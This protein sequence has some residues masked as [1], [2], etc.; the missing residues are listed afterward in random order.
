[1]H[2]WN[3]NNGGTSHGEQPFDSDL[4]EAQKEVE[5]LK[6]KCCEDKDKGGKNE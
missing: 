1:M 3:Q 6:C 5:A 2:A 4:P